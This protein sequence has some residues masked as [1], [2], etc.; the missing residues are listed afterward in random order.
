ML[1]VRWGGLGLCSAASLVTSAFLTSSSAVRNFVH[2]MLPAC[3]G[4]PFESSY[5]GALAFWQSLGGTI[6]SASVA[7]RQWDSQICSAQFSSLISESNKICKARLLGRSPAP[8]G[9]LLRALPSPNLGLHLGNEELCIA[10]GLWLGCPHILPDSCVCGVKVSSDGTHGLPYRRSAGRHS[11]YSVVNEILAIA[12][13]SPDI[14]VALEIT[15]LFR[16]NVK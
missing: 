4:Q 7:Q 13:Q 1:P 11:R 9:S 16:G 15:G 3:G 14:P 2:S 6:V 5:D 12:F 10:V 8:S